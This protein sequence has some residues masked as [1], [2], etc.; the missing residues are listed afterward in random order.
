MRIHKNIY[1][2]VAALLLCLAFGAAPAAAQGRANG[3]VAFERTIDG[4]TDIF[5]VN[6]DGS[7]E[8]NLTETPFNESQPAWSPD[9]S[10]L[11]F[12][13]AAQVAGETTDLYIMD[14]DGHNLRRLTSDD[15]VER[16]PAWSPDGT[17]IAYARTEAQG[18]FEQVYTVSSDGFELKNLTA[19][20]RGDHSHPSW[21][22]D[23]QRIAFASSSATLNNYEIWVM[24]ADGT[25]PMQL[26][27]NDPAYCLSPAWSPDGNQIVYTRDYEIYL[28]DPQTG[29]E[30]NLTDSS[31]SEDTPEWSPDGKQIVF[32]RFA[33][34]N[35]DLYTMKADGTEQ[36]RLTTDAQLD[37][38]PAWS[39][40]WS[41]AATH[42][43]GITVLQPG[44]KPLAGVKLTLSGG[45][46]GAQTTDEGG[47]ATFG[48]LPAGGTYTINASKD[49][50]TFTPESRTFVNVTEET[51][52]SFQAF[53]AVVNTEPA[54]V[55]FSAA[56]YSAN[57][58]A[59][60][61]TVR[62][63]RTG[64]AGAEGAVFYE[65][66]D[67][68]AS[69]RGDYTT[70]LG[71]LRFAAGE[72][73][74]SF[75]VLLTD[76]AYA[77]GPEALTLTLSNVT[78]GLGAGGTTSATLVIEDDDATHGPNPAAEAEFFV[79][80]HYH[81]FLN[82][83]PDAAGLK[84]WA[85]QL[86]ACG[87]DAGCLDHVRQNVSAAFFLSIEFQQTGFLVQRLQ[88]VSYGRL[89][90]YRDYVR[91]TQEMGRG[92]VVGA[93]GWRE[94]LESNKR[95]FVAAWAARAEFAA[96]YEA[97]SDA[98]FVDALWSNAGLTAAASEREGLLADLAGGTL[99]RADA[100]RRVAESEPVVA[101]EFNPAFVLMEYFGYLRRN[102]D[103]RPDADMSGY[104]FWLD[105]FNGFGGDYHRA[106]M[107][108]A[109]IISLEYQRRF[110]PQ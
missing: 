103:D 106:E 101:A 49:G 40:A 98:Q 5:V 6:A 24:Q 18:G 105:K 35:L 26:T 86:A 25:R 19:N 82:R 100:V 69:E 2:A 91:D 89:P 15:A 9:G 73:E 29:A 78:G 37:S 22:P 94:R 108:K 68:T 90:R 72:M 3:R 53:S 45:A 32:S 81:D 44:E 58:S 52:G 43:I 23:S 31:L 66:Q 93:G 36:R 109:F 88:R 16:F 65:T 46:S 51:S 4:A 74:K 38:Q 84:F 8:R 87:G 60:V 57:E 67:G 30:T 77:E 70:A 99:T 7:G 13:R 102:P 55:Q 107:V 79:R 92:V 63:T 59:H 71:T 41:P 75:D 1:A 61:F 33:E 42:S 47:S 62:V 39:P 34:G 83:E 56:S 27:S 11:V 95:A 54:R 21:S 20:L 12:V 48:N 104:Y 14:A 10:R 85:D 96:K 80:Q 76:D 97:M 28:L 110:G 17:R 64:D 50:Y